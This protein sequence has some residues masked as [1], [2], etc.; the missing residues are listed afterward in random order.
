MKS[1][2]VYFLDLMRQAKLTKLNGPMLMLLVAC[3]LLFTILMASIA[4]NI[5]ENK[6]II[7]YYVLCTRCGS[8]IFTFIFFLFNLYLRLI[9]IIINIVEIASVLVLLLVIKLLIV[10]RILVTSN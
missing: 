6:L 3:C 5:H 4:S 8:S 7:V 9:L 10:R 2:K 1:G